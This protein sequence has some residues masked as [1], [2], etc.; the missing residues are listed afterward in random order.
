MTREEIEDLIYV[1][2]P[3]KQ[4]GENQIDFLLSR[5]DDNFDFWLLSMIF[6]NAS[7]RYMS[8]ARGEETIEDFE[9]WLEGLPERVRNT[10]RK[11]GFDAAKST[12]P[13]RR[14]VMELVRTLGWMNISKDYYAWQ[15]GKSG[16]NT[17]KAM[18]MTNEI[19]EIEIGRSSPV[20]EVLSKKW[21]TTPARV[22]RGGQHPTGLQIGH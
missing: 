1:K 13:F 11:E 4:T 21:P 16:M 15:I 19:M 6:G 2:H 17:K 5:V 7:Y 18:E 20:S 9:D 12:W 14:H 3:H 8:L 22:Y 10:F